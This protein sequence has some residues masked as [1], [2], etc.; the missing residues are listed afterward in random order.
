MS[1]EGS[2]Q[3]LGLLKELCVYK[4]MDEDY[5]GGARSEAETEAYKRRDRRRQEIREEMQ[6]LATESKSDPP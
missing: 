1:N 4:T 6:A 2:E 3:M 5:A